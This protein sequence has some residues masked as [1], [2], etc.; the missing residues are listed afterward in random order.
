LK[1]VDLLVRAGVVITPDIIGAYDQTHRA[2]RHAKR[3]AFNF[4]KITDFHVLSIASLVGCIG[5]VD[6]AQGIDV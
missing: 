2:N 6:L 1:F 3:G 4:N 5:A